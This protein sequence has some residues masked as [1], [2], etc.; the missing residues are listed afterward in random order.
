MD[1]K[2]KDGFELVNEDE[3]KRHKEIQAFIPVVRNAVS[4]AWRLMDK[5]QKLMDNKEGT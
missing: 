4:K 5:L 2:T 1:L 3:I